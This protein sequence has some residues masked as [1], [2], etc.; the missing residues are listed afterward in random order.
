MR[1][2]PNSGAENSCHG[3]AGCLATE[4][5]NVH[6]MIA[7]FKNTT[8]YMFHQRNAIQLMLLYRSSIVESLNFI[9]HA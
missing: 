6:F 7:Y 3:N 8:V 9:A 5:R 2:T 1:T 4:P